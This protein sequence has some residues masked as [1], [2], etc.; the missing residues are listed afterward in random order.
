[1]ELSST[2]LSAS[3]RILV[4][5]SKSPSVFES[6]YRSGQIYVI[7]TWFPSPFAWVVMDYVVTCRLTLGH[8]GQSHCSR[9][10]RSG[11][12]GL[13]PAPSSPGKGGPRSGTPGFTAH[14]DGHVTGTAGVM[15]AIVVAVSPRVRVGVYHHEVVG[16]AGHQEKGDNWAKR[17]GNPTLTRRQHEARVKYTWPRKANWRQQLILNRLYSHKRRA[18]V[19]FAQNKRSCIRQQHRRTG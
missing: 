5:R 12:L 13:L 18:V 11:G 6:E 19:V 17:G 16:H 10:R 14:V 15:A 9:P 4:F 3:G 1:T 7:S 2:P 8:D